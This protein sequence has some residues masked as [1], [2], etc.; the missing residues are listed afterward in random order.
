MPF[1]ECKCGRFTAW[2]KP[3]P[4]LL[5]PQCW[6]RHW[7]GKKSLSPSCFFYLK[8]IEVWEL[9]YP[10]TFLCC[11]D[12]TKDWSPKTDR[13]V[14][15]PVKITH[16]RKIQRAVAGGELN[17]IDQLFLFLH[18]INLLIYS[19]QLKLVLDW[20][21]DAVEGTLQVW[22]H[23]KPMKCNFSTKLLQI[24]QKSKIQLQFPLQPSCLMF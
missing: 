17:Q 20:S 11:S 8:F 12:A 13:D 18:H 1:C 4:F 9:D 24:Y 5:I 6:R 2:S 19:F 14:R 15:T 22:T 16:V 23:K 10:V 21:R 3:F 7:G